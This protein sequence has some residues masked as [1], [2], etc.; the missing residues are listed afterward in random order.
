MP[1]LRAV[2]G[3]INTH[4]YHMSI[5]RDAYTRVNVPVIKTSR[6]V[7]AVGSVREPERDESML[8]D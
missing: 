3:I 6:T 4:D 2:S 1:W 8:R 5:K 7:A